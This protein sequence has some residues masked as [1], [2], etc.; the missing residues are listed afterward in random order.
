[1]DFEYSVYNSDKKS[2]LNK[3]IKE[4]RLKDDDSLIEFLS[5][6]GIFLKKVRISKGYSLKVFCDKYRLN[7]EVICDL[8]NG[9]ILPDLLLLDIYLR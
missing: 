9:F 4:I 6:L 3:T 7:P 5:N 1:V 8:E 2:L